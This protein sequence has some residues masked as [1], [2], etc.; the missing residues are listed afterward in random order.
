MWLVYCSH[1]QARTTKLRSVLI[2]PELWS[3]CR[4]FLQK[5]V[6]HCEPLTSPQGLMGK[7]MPVW[8]LDPPPLTCRDQEFSLGA[9]Q[10]SRSHH[11]PG[12]VEMGNLWTL[13]PVWEVVLTFGL[14]DF[15]Q[16]LE[17]ES[18][19]ASISRY[20]VCESLTLGICNN[21]INPDLFSSAFGCWPSPCHVP[22]AWRDK[23]WPSLAI[24]RW[25][26]RRTWD[27]APPWLKCQLPG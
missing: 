17:L 13:S 23:T 14:A 7:H 4:S 10:T 1:C 26:L 18:L 22:L 20:V 3:F 11:W 2:L 9:S 27:L 5:C 15:P 6:S 19:V 24:F 21:Y 12:R 8:C 25:L 16:V